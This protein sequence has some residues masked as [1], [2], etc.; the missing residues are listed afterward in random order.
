MTF[1]GEPSAPATVSVMRAGTLWMVG[2]LALGCAEPHGPAQGLLATLDGALSQAHGEGL[3]ARARASLRNG[4][5]DPAL[6]ASVATS[7]DPKHRR[8]AALLAAIEAPADVA[9]P[10]STAQEELDDAPK[11]KLSTAPPP[12]EAAPTQP[13]V[14]GASAPAPPR[15][16]PAARVQLEHV[17]LAKTKQGA[18]LSLRG[19]GGLV[20]GVASQPASGIVRLV[21]EA[22]A[23]TAAL[24][25]RP[26]VEGARITGIRRTG[27]SVFVTLALDPGWSLRGIVRTR[28]GARV[29]L[30]RP[31]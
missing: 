25:S 2:L 30:R 26:R 29:D 19:S 9:T 24:R 17:G 18:S 15:P 21:V 22:D 10:P 1:W 11:I 31:V 13:A 4:E 23:S 7:V 8:A 5:V 12:V 3:L 27:K 28:G 16:A 20:V 14:R 6:A